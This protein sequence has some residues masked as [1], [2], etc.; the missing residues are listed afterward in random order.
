MNTAYSGPQLFLLEDNAR[1]HIGIEGEALLCAGGL[2]PLWPD[3]PEP[4]DDT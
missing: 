2:C 3:L 1:A 4:E